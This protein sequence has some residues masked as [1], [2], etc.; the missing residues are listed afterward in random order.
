MARFSLSKDKNFYLHYVLTCAAFLNLTGCGSSLKLGAPGVP[1]SFPQPVFRS[2]EG[3]STGTEGDQVSGACSVDQAPVKPLIKFNF[4]SG[5]IPKLCD[6]IL[7]QLDRELKSLP[8]L[9]LSKRNFENVFLKYESTLSNFYSFYL[10]LSFP[11]G[12]STD[13]KIREESTSCQDKVGKFMAEVSSRKDLYEAMKD[14]RP[15]GSVEEK[16]HTDVMRMF[17][18]AGMGLPDEKISKI[19]DLNSKLAQ[20]ENEFEQNLTN[21]SDSQTYSARELDGVPELALE[22]F[23]KS[24]DG[25]YVVTAKT[26]DYI[27]VAD[28]AHSPETRKRNLIVYENQ[29]F[30]EN[31]RIFQEILKLRREVALVLGYRTWADIRLE[32]KMAKKVIT[33]DQFLKD[34]RSKLRIPQKRD[35]ARLLKFKKT[36]D[37]QSTEIFPWDTRYL[38]NQI[39]KREYQVDNELISE[40]FPVDHVIAGM[41]KI[42]SQL[43]GIEIL[44]IP[45]APVWHPSV[46]L[47]Q[48]REKGSCSVLAHFYMDNFPRVG[49]RGGAAAY[50]LVMGQQRPQ[51]YVAPVSAIVANYNPPTGD[52]P[53]LLSHDQVETLFHEFGHIMHQ[54]LTKVPYGSISGTNVDW[55][56]VE[57]PS[58]ML[59]HWVW[60]EKVLNELSGH[61]KDP[62][63][64]LPRA[65]IRKMVAAKKFNEANM[66][67][68]QVLLASYDMA[69]HTAD[70]DL[71]IHQTYRK[72]FRDFTGMKPNEEGHF[73]TTFGHI[74]GGYNAG[75]YGYLWSEVYAD[76]MFSVFKASTKGLFDSKVGMNYRK[77]ILEVGGTEDPLILLNKFLGRKPRA[78]AFMEKFKMT[79]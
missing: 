24:P 9:P 47:Y 61:Y 54:T 13:A 65:Q 22:R 73:A 28:N 46:K 25:K 35:Q 36:L 19:R 5:E 77:K 23:Q 67:N 29:S 64:K 66:Y 43:L 7:E 74:V 45:R 37:P 3:V 70:S 39:K 38:A 20:L 31:T 62:S 56:F 14:L 59:E 34:L 55:D 32:D 52:K 63:K 1:D 57:A 4:K 69:L 44:E 15:S 58:Q 50:T 79:K 27:A 18:H 72:M 6:Q 75:Y 78:D 16:M 11:S 53:S 12:V 10:Q 17:R 51:G 21:N 8:R 41:F 48:I 30:R 2:T 42:Y 49:K 60:D 68:R 33:V 71:D 40:F 26:P 76:D